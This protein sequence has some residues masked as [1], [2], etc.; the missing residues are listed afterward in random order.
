MFWSRYK[1]RYVYPSKPQILYIMGFKG[2][3][4]AQMFDTYLHGVSHF[5]PYLTNG[6]SHHYRLGESTFIFRGV[7][8]DFNFLSHFLNFSLQKE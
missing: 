7:R 8:S 6:F 5:N 3:F 1:K 2:V 4:I